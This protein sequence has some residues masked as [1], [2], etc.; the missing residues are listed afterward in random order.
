M[1][2]HHCLYRTDI[3]P[4]Y[5]NLSDYLPAIPKEKINIRQ[6][7][8]RSYVLRGDVIYSESEFQELESA[9][10]DV[11]AELDE[12]KLEQ[13]SL[14]KKIKLMA[15]VLYTRQHVY[16]ERP[17][18]DP[19]KFKQ[20]LEN[21]EPSLR[22]FFDQLVARTN[23]Q[24]KSN[25]TNE[26]NKIRL[27]SF[28]YFLAG[29]NNKFINGIKAEVGLLLN[30]SGASSSA[31]ETLAGAGL[32]VRRE[33]IARQKARHVQAVGAFLA[34]NVKSLVVLNIDDFHN[35]HEFCRSNT[36]N[37]HDIA[38]FTTILLKALPEKLSIPFNNSNQEKSIHNNKGI[39]SDIIIENA[40]SLFFPHLWLSYTGQ[41][42][43]FNDLPVQ[44]THDERI[45]CLLIHSY[46]DR[47]EQCQMDRS[48]KNTRLV[49]LK[50]GFLHSTE[51]YMNVLKSLIDV[52]EA[53]TYMK[54]Q[55][56]VTPMDYPGQLCVRR[57]IYPSS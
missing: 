8:D 19:E 17:I 20:M 5:N 53:N 51:D 30:A 18:L 11:C 25:I 40:N 24:A 54:T 46:D 27:V 37:T 57:A 9:Y 22:G 33:T 55:V 36:T 44:E 50:K 32:T 2:C 15:G 52:P 21:A 26:K 16:N 12:A 28:C 23:P 3:D 29:L 4:E 56:L 43:A 47:I 34:E 41:K 6:F 31:I 10:H 1:M 42:N 38:H 45:E 14:S 7:Q 35:I 39:D 48:M 49:D 13:I